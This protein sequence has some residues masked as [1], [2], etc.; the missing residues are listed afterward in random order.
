MDEKR[1][2]RKELKKQNL[3][4]SKIRNNIRTVMI[5]FITALMV[6]ITGL[7]GASLAYFG[8]FLSGAITLVQI[9]KGFPIEDDFSTVLQAEKMGTGLSVLTDDSYI[10]YSPTAKEVFNYSHAMLKPVIDTSKNRAVIYDLNGST[11]KIANGHNILF[12]KE[13]PNSIIHVDLSDSNRVAVTTRSSS[14]NGEVAVFNYNMNQRF[15]WYCAKGYPIYSA[16]S[17]SGD[18]LAVNTVQTKDGI[19]TSS[20]FVID[21]AKGEELFSIDTM[22]YAL[23]IEFLS[24]DRILIAYPDRLILYSVSKNDVIASYELTGGNLQ[25]IH[26][27]GSYITVCYGGSSRQQSSTLAVLTFGFEEKFNVTVPEKIKDLSMSQS[28]I[29]ALGYDN[30]YEYDYSANLVNTTATGPLYK[31]LADYNGT[32]IISSTSIDKVEKT[33]K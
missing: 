27:D 12:R 30:M 26:T 21:A 5:L 22:D 16:L 24:D 15:V 23:K 2:S 29:F 19:L 8:D 10:V 13:M 9:G 4:K 28:R 11:L 25:A 7:Y 6:Y 14:Y 32:L 31:Q 3:K 20:I 1:I 18:M 33:K 17:D